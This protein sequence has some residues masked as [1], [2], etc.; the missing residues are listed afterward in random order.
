MSDVLIHACFG[1]NLRRVRKIVKEDVPELKL[2]ILK[3]L[4]EQE[5]RL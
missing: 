3:I 4:E 1:V 2:K 5:I